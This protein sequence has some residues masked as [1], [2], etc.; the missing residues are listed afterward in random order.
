MSIVVKY[1]ADGGKILD[2]QRAVIAKD[3]AV[4]IYC[5]F[6][7]IKFTYDVHTHQ[8]GIGRGGWS[9][10]SKNDCCFDKKKNDRAK[11]YT[12]YHNGFQ[13]LTFRMKYSS[14]GGP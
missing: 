9:I 1:D 4:K 5:S 14:D 3:F 12:G 8:A 11:K 2:N 10:L 13:W 7:T 6:R